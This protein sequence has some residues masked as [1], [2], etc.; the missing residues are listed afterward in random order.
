MDVTVRLLDAADID[1]ARD[2]Q[3]R[4]F[5]ALDR[6][7]GE[8]SWEVTPEVVERQRARFRHFLTNDPGG[9]WVAESGGRVVGTALALRREGLWGLSLLVVD[10]EHQSRG[11]GR[12]LLDASLTYAEDV[13]TAVI[14]SSRDGRAMRRYAA[15][16]FDLF[17]QVGSSGP[18]DRS[19][20]QRPEVPVRTGGPDDADLADAVDRLVRGAARG[21]D[22]PAMA[23]AGA[24]FVVDQGGRRGYAYQR[25]DG[26]LVTIA[27][28][29]E[30]TAAALLWEYLGYDPDGTV[31]RTVDHLNAE[32]QWAVRVV[33]AAGLRLAAA[34][35]AFWRG[36][37]PPRCF[38]PDGTYL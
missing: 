10:P 6:H 29:D 38:I 23:A 30:T 11:V 1:E 19:R 37:T 4:A 3:T 36:R 13:P 9:S 27:A 5:Q 16:G 26:R 22:H 33:V 17:P 35:P 31:S 21:P 12:A 14:L 18:V 32:Q 20:L 24:M 8:P 34:G 2:V 15:A 28:T 7:F 25:A